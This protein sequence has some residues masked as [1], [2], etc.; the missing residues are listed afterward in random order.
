MTEKPRPEIRLR[1]ATPDD[2]NRLLEWR[3]HPGT[4]RASF[5]QR[6]VVPDEHRSW[7]RRSLSDP[8]RLILIA[9]QDG[10]AVGM[11]RFDKDAGNSAMI[12]IMIAP[13]DQKRGFAFEV[14]SL[15]VTMRPFGCA[16]FKAQIRPEN[17]SS[18]KLF[19]KAGFHETNRTPDLC[20]FEYE[21]KNDRQN[22]I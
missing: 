17:T 10:R 4:R 1:D 19:Q 8:D 7:F 5:A 15:G 6:K 21:D 16:R 18:L 2:Q 13:Q 12:S 9:E 11:L 20:E 3:N 14:L 22:Q